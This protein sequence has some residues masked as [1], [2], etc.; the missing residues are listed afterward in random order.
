M[1][2][3]KK[4]R[5]LSRERNEKK[6]K[7]LEKQKVWRNEQKGTEEKDLGLEYRSGREG[8]RVQSC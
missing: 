3:I 1:P 7:Q 8:P 2:V 4:K 6:K 5:E